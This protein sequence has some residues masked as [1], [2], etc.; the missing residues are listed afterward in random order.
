MITNI[1]ITIMV[2]TS[3]VGFDIAHAPKTLAVEQGASASVRG[4]YETEGESPVEQTKITKLE[5]IEDE[6]TI[7]GYI[8]QKFGNGADDALVVLQGTGEGSCAENR[9]LDPQ[10]V[11]D[12]TTWGGVGQ[13]VGYWQINNV[14]HPTVTEEC[15]KD[16]K[17]STDYA[18]KLYKERGDF[19][20]WTCGRRYG[21]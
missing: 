1:V 6:D 10:A 9:H 18:Y 5:I 2:V 20:A 11:N 4:Q 17:C 13:D 19:S 3:I 14:Y 12:N 21:L 7:E 8:R 16:V 15:A